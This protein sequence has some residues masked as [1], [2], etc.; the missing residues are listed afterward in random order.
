MYY[1]KDNNSSEALSIRVDPATRHLLEHRAKIQHLN[2]SKYLRQLINVG[3]EREREILT[4]NAK[5]S[6]RSL[7]LTYSF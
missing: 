2:L 6:K 5:Y 7:N 3:L 1:E 4:G